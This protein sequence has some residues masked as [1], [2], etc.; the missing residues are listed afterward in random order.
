MYNGAL[1]I[2]FIIFTIPIYHLRK[3]YDV[4]YKESYNSSFHQQ[5]FEV[6]YNLFI[7]YYIFLGNSILHHASIF[8][9]G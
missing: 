2:I 5:I 3:L 9:K 4:K 6:F 7:E 1:C 8:K